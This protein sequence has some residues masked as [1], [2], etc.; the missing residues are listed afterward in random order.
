MGN[1]LPQ[2][3]AASERT[4]LC[5]IKGSVFLKS[6]PREELWKI[7]EQ[8][9]WKEVDLTV[10]Q[11]IIS[12]QNEVFIQINNNLWMIAQNQSKLEMILAV[13]EESSDTIHIIRCMSL[14]QFKNLVLAIFYS[15]RPSWIISPL[16]QCC[17]TSFTVFTRNHHCRNCGKNICGGCSTFAKLEMSGYSKEQRIC[18]QCVRIVKQC[19]DLVFDIQVNEF[20]MYSY[21]SLY[22]FSDTNSV[23]TN[24]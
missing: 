4:K 2:E 7:L 22:C 15:K 17:S 3:Q 13:H 21:D 6:A 9:T 5:P 12:I 23:I 16:C 10:H 24:F 19:S 20:K 1:K 8:N 18:I 11:S 14:H